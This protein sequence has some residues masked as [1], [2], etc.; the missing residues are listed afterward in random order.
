MREETV[1][2]QTRTCEETMTQPPTHDLNEILLGVSKTAIVIVNKDESRVSFEKQAY[3]SRSRYICCHHDAPV[4]YF[5][6]FNLSVLTIL[7]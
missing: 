5:A 6:K 2:Q 1:T 7:G 3:A 4:Q